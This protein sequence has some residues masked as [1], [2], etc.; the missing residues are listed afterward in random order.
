MSL[1]VHTRWLFHWRKQYYGYWTRILAGSKKWKLKMFELWIC[2][3]QTHK[4]QLITSQN[5]N[6]WTGVVWITCGLLWCFYQLFGLSFWR[7]PFT[8]EDLLVSKWRN[9]TFL[10][11]WSDEETN[12]TIRQNSR[13]WT[14][15]STKDFKY[16]IDRYAFKSHG[17]ECLQKWLLISN[18]ITLS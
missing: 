5:V 11:I 16:K 8:T 18:T 10:Q 2:F 13:F 9:A 4:K 15:P 14:M 6:W 12:S 1:P 3:L 7:H 17:F